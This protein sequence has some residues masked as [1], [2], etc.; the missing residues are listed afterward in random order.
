MASTCPRCGKSL[1]ILKSPV[2][3]LMATGHGWRGF[4]SLFGEALR[5][6]RGCGAVYT[7][8]GSLLAGAAV[9]TAREA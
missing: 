8:D 3:S 9:E 7:A 6:C 4:K 2:K 1:E 5:S